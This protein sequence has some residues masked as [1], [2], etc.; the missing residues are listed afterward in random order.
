MVG[1]ALRQR[2]TKPEDDRPFGQFQPVGRAEARK[3]VSKRAASPCGDP[4]QQ[5]VHRFNAVACHQLFDPLAKRMK[6]LATTARLEATAI[7]S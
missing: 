1:D 7:F 4:K 6:R 2:G 3:L 5:P